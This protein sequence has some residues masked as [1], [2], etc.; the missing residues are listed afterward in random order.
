MKL[1]HLVLC[2][3][4][5]PLPA[6]A[7]QP[8]YPAEGDSR[9]RYV[10]Y[11]AANVVKI[12]AKYG[13]QTFVKFAND[14]RIEDL[15][16]GDTAAWEIGV[17]QRPNSFFIKPKDRSPNTNI[18]V[19]TNK[20]FYNFELQLYTGRAQNMYMVLFRYPSEEAKARSAADSRKRTEKLLKNGSAGLAQNRNY[21]MQGS[22]SIAP[23]EAWDDG[24]FTHL[25]FAPRADFPAVY[26][27]AEDGTETLANNHPED[28]GAV[29]V[30]HRVA[31]KLV[32]R[33]GN[34]VTCI[35]NES[36]EPVGIKPPTNTK[37]PAVERVI[38]GVE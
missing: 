19:I 12:V 8:T 29:I 38:R 22:D 33:K 23:I 13:R 18:T 36:F 37:S 4:L 31:K 34:L 16:G 1:T 25:R 11:D 14:E 21:M 17:A 26:Y 30:V 20:R 32:L 7:I 9:I 3:V 6:L 2:A 35:F 27:V 24:Q 10:D 28:D 5:L 15:G